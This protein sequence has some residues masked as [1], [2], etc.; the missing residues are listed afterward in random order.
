MQSIRLDETKL[1]LDPTEATPFRA[2]F[3]EARRGNRRTAAIA[4]E[5]ETETETDKVDREWV[6]QEWVDREWAD[7]RWAGSRFEVRIQKRLGTRAADTARWNKLGRK[8]WELV[9]VDRKHA[10]FRR[11][12]P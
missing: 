10:F 6:D 11:E 4:T 3:A 7:Q 9:A 5:T 12:H 2:A 1:D 8:G